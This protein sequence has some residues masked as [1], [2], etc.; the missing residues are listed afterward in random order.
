[1]SA[2]TFFKH[3]L[4]NPLRMGSIV[5]SSKALAHRMV[6]DLDLE[7]DRVVI[8]LG[9]GTGAFSQELARRMN[10]RGTLILV[11]RSEELAVVLRQRFPN[12]V[13]IND[14]VSKLGVHM[15]QLGLPQADYIV[16]GLP[17]TLFDPELQEQ[18]LS[19]VRAWL[20]PGGTFVTF[21]YLHGMRFMNLGVKFEARLKHLLGR[22]EKSRPVWRNLPPARVW[23]WHRPLH[24][25]S[26]E[27]GGG[28]S[29]SAH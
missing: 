12:A 3:W 26:G 4:Q 8:E 29:Q 19:Q 5:P 23:T 21:I 9:S 18:A 13:V 14:C 1:M 27:A 20:R 16:S 15:E 17:W 6:Q 24:L 2:L 11:E 10:G 7:G 28:H 25:H 22:F